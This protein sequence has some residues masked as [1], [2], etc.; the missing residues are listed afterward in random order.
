LRLF[1]ADYTGSIDG[2]LMS[3]AAIEKDMDPRD[4]EHVLALYDAEIRFTDDVLRDIFDD[5]GARGMLENTLTIVTADHGEEFFEHGRKGHNKTLYDEVLRIPLIMHWPGEVAAG[6]R[7][8]VQVQLIDLMPTLIRAAGVDS[9]P[10]VQG[11]DL[12]PL[13]AGGELAERDALAELLIDGQGLRALRSNKRKVIEVS[14]GGPAFFLDLLQH[15]GE[16]S[17]LRLGAEMTAAEEQRRAQGQ[18]EL[19]SAVQRSMEFKGALEAGDLELGDELNARL[20]ALGY[21]G[22]DDE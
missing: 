10:G 18:R 14:R 15:P 16:D 3:N 13:M 11:R 6:Q 1:D 22:D 12:G 19:D 8:G 7:N 20:R 5:L 17:W 21:L 9:G 2:R 4:L